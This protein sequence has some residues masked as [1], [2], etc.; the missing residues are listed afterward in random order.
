M[1]SR[2]RPALANML[3]QRLSTFSS[4]SNRLRA[5]LAMAAAASM[6]RRALLAAVEYAP[7]TLLM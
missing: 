2:R 5:E 1:S 3:G 6:R 7:L 4:N